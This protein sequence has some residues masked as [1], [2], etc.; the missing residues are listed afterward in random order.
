MTS[1]AELR[2]LG[3]LALIRPEGSVALGGPKSQLLL[4]MLIAN[5]PRRLSNDRLIDG[6]WG[7]APPRSAMATLQS[8][9]SRLRS[10]I[11]PEFEIVY[12]AMGYRLEAIT[13]TLDSRRFENF[14]DRSLNRAQDE[15]TQPLQS[16]FAADM[17][18]ALALWRGRAFG[19]FAEHSEVAGEARRLDEMRLVAIDA[20]A[21]EQIRSGDPVS[22]VGELESLVRNHPLRESFRR[23]LTLALY[24][25]GRQAEALR[26]VSEFRSLLRD[27]AGLSISPGLKQ[28]EEQ[29]LSDD[30][31][32]QTPRVLVR[33]RTEGATGRQLLGVTSFF[34]RDPHVASIGVAIRRESVV[35]ITG[36]GGVGKTRLAMHVAGTVGHEFGNGVVVVELAALRDPSGAAQVIANA[37]DIQQRQHR[38]IEDTIEDFLA[39]LQ[40]LLLLDNCEHLTTEIAPL[41]DRLRL[42]CPELRILA[43]SRQPLGLAAEYIDVLNPL[44]VPTPAADSVDQVRRASAVELFVSRASSGH[45]KFE[46]T[47]KN[48]KAVSEVCRRLDG[49]PLALELAA[50]RLRTMSIH[51]LVDRLAVRTD[52]PGQT[53][54]G[55]DG[56]QRSVR[57][58]VDWSYDLLDPAERYFF[59]QLSVF[60]GGFDS[61]AVRAVC[62]SGDAALDGADLLVGLVDKSMVI[63]DGPSS[64]RYRLLEPLREYGLERLTERGGLRDAEHRH[65]EWFRSRAMQAS[66][67]LNGPEEGRWA[68]RIGEDFDNFRAAFL[69]A[70]RNEN[71]DGALSLVASLRE[72]AFREI[73]YEVTKWA[74]TAVALE[75]A[76]DGSCLSTVLGVVSYGA[77]VHGDMPRA[78]ELA[79]RALAV[80]GES[81]LSESGLPERV[82]SNALFYME[83][84]DEAVVWM[85]RMVLSGRTSGDTAQTAHALYMS[86]VAQTSI[87]DAIGGAVLAGEAREAAM[88]CGSPTAMAQA[89]YALGLALEQERPDEALQQLERACRHAADAGNRWLEAF[90]LTEVYSLKAKSGELHEALVGYAEVIETWYRGGDW[91]N[92]YLSLRGVFSIFVEIG[93]HEA[94]AVL[95]G[96]LAAVGASQAMPIVPA[97]AE[98][99]VD[100]VDE[101]QAS[102]D[103]TDFSSAV[104]KGA[105]L[106]DAEIVEFVKRQ[107]RSLTSE[108]R[109]SA[110]GQQT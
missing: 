32:L 81:G 37:L 17:E 39:P 57:D 87:G 98:R 11:C 29:V 108:R 30:P 14:V 64:S 51:D 101:L 43:T 56:R 58:L 8:Q 80:P 3:S 33:R 104:R 95:H 36:P 85:D 69:V 42:A 10:L 40:V 31:A 83:K 16:V 109:A 22:I 50:A 12:E 18:S 97:E 9:I 38:T 28:L 53:Q 105:T 68:T 19:Q 60:A 47:E 2:V 79:R 54:I 92:Q 75:G 62:L 5:A 35:T 13:G 93:R 84:T 90:A 86:S 74:E 99:L 27:E 4:T 46:L 100:Q 41:V 94:G 1:G 91:A 72:N 23:F 7:E 110:T 77:F 66:S 63:F 71:A 61:S 78:I 34:G 67:E 45:H 6:L 65:Y 103:P 20:W 48:A 73:K 76:E 106:K 88:S 24:Q 59:E 52:M 82:L 102:M 96:A 55:A 70:I 15:R 49:L 89:A 25:T 107:I 21:A 26:T 44:G